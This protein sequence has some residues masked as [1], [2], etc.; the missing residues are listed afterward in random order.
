MSMILM[1]VRLGFDVDNHHKSVH[2]YGNWKW[3]SV[4]D[5]VLDV[6]FGLDILVQ[7]RTTY[8]VNQSTTVPK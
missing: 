3:L 5:W 4:Y 6:A 1:P 2:K 7:F 8:K